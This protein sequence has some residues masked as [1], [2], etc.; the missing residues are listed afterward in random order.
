VNLAGKLIPTA[1]AAVA[2]VFPGAASAATIT[3]DS[4]LDDG[5]GCTLR[6]AVSS[7]ANDN[8]VGTCIAGAGHDEIV[9]PSAVGNVIQLEG[10][11]ITVTAGGLGDITITGPGA[12]LLDVR[13]PRPVDAF[14]VFDVDGTGDVEIGGLTVSN[15]LAEVEDGG[16]IR[17]SP[18]STVNLTLDQVVVKGNRVNGFALGGGGG[19]AVA[20]SGVTTIRRSTVSSNE[21]HILGG[22]VSAHGAGIYDAGPGPIVIDG[23]TISGNTVTA[24]ALASTAFSAGAGIYSTN[25]S[26]VTIQRST[27]S[28]NTATTGGGETKVV[29][30][31]GVFLNT[32]GEIEASTI[33]SNT[34]DLGSNLFFVGGTFRSTLVANP[35]GGFNCNYTGLGPVDSS[36]SLES[37]GDSCEFDHATDQVNVADPGLD[38]TLTD[39]GGPTLTHGLLPT[40]P[41]VD[42]GNSFGLAGGDQRG[43][44]RPV[45]FLGIPNAAGGDGAD[46]GAFEL[47]RDCASQ[48]IPNGD[49]STGPTIPPTGQTPPSSGSTP[50]GPTGRRAAALK[51]CNKAK[52]KKRKQCK[53]RARRLP[54]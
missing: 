10:S 53:K 28:G 51:K 4:N 52:G 20:G 37:P 6:N 50:P 7:A 35:I 9:I 40:S 24:T 15:G 54:A 47:A 13:G 32:D 31:G 11:E 17:T 44:E 19:I 49:C 36:F 42:A 23:S 1:V 48:A 21:V 3:V 30:G 29:A 18:A 16:G 2:A 34:A 45:D 8:S 38:L 22:P 27:V 39:N 25:G 26:N 41:A 43:L 5:A 33:A 46:I 14:R 12:G